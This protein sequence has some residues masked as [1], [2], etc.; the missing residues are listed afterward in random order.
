M[1]DEIAK[2]KK[3]SRAVKELAL[4]KDKPK[5]KPTWAGAQSLLG[6]P[7]KGSKEDKERLLI[8]FT[9]RAMNISPFGVTILGNL[10][11]INKLGLI[12]KAQEYHGDVG[13]EYNWVQIA[14]DDT[15]KAI[16]QC[17]MVKKD[18]KVLSDWVLGECS[19]ST[20]RMSSL[21]GYQNHMAQTRARN[22]CI[23]EVDGA[24]IHE[25]MIAGIEQL[26]K[27]KASKSEN[28]AEKVARNALTSAEEMETPSLAKQPELIKQDK[29]KELENLFAYALA[30]GAPVGQ[31]KE[32]I[33]KIV[34]RQVDWENLTL[35]DALQL[36]TDI[37]MGKRKGA[38]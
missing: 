6:Q 37:L 34:G 3:P 15:E 13:F 29:N 28:F 23:M 27:E 19:P 24:R 26:Q 10:P 22:R 4:E 31:E 11:Y 32:F 21:K 18:G 20:I 7:V 1:S 36:K 8:I 2:P 12:Q 25:D 16:C 33:E 30:N 9:A 17:R 14:K 35:K 38:V 5:E